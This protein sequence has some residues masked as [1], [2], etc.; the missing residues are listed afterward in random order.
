MLRCGAVLLSPSVSKRPVACCLTYVK[1]YERLSPPRCM[2][3][4]TTRTLTAPSTPLLHALQPHAV[5]PASGRARPTPTRP[6]ATA[7]GGVAAA[8]RVLNS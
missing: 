5:L 3:A 7:R 4:G 8:P 6:T 1:R 2:S